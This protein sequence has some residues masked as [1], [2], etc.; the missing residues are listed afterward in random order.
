MPRL[1]V[2]DETSLQRWYFSTGRGI[3]GSRS[4]LV[5]GGLS[6]RATCGNNE[7][8]IAQLEDAGESSAPLFPGGVMHFALVPLALLCKGD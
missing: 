4:P 1:F 6:A 5:V 8:S 2:H 3:A 7:R